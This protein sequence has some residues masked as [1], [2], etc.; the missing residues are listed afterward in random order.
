MRRTLLL[1]TLF[2][3]LGV[4]DVAAGQTRT[5]YT[6]TS[7]RMRAAPSTDARVLGRVPAGRAVAVDGCARDWCRVR[8]AGRDGWMAERYLRD[9]PA[10]AATWEA[11][12]ERT[13]SSDGASGTHR[14][15]VNSA[16]EL[17][18]SPRRSENGRVPAG[19][20]ARCRDGTYS[21]SR[22]RRGTC[23]HHGGVAV[24]L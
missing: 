22:S 3:S 16:G 23:S 12:R 7:V 15:Y 21:F 8:H 5:A 14:T 18:Q 17:V 9:R 24:W 2:L 4:V 19:A 1:L 13:R 20:S 10:L 11:P 6:T